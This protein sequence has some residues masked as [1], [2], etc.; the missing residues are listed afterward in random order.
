MD[1]AVTHALGTDRTV[2]ITTTGRRSGEQRRI[3]IWMHHLD[4]RHY[5]TG[6]PGRRSWYAN[7]VADPRFVL[8]L[9]ESAQADLAATARPVTDAAERRAVLEPVLA[10]LGREPQLDAWLDGA[11]LVEFELSDPSKT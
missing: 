4:G 8:H 6:I 9:K 3:E 1:D 10:G 5:I 2:D 7:L 11:P